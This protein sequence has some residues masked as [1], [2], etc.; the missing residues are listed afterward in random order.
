[1]SRLVCFFSVGTD[2]K[3]LV[4]EWNGRSHPSRYMIEAALQL[5]IVAR[6]DDAI[7][8]S[9][10]LTEKTS[11]L[12]GVMKAELAGQNDDWKPINVHSTG[13][14]A[15][16]RV[17]DTM[18]TTV[19]DGDRVFIEPTNGPRPFQM[20]LIS[21]ALYL[22]ALRG[23]VR[24]ERLVYG[25][26]PSGTIHDITFVLELFDWTR[27]AHAFAG[28]LNSRPLLERLRNPELDELEVPL[29][30]GLTP[31]LFTKL[32]SFRLPGGEGLAQREALGLV[33]RRLRRLKVLVDRT[34]EGTLDLSWLDAELAFI[35]ELANAGR[36]SDATR[37][38][39]EWCVNVVL[40]AMGNTREW[41]STKHRKPAEQWLLF[42]HSHSPGQAPIPEHF[43]KFARLYQRL[44]RLR[45]T[46]SHSGY[47]QDAMALPQLAEAREH[48]RNARV[49]WDANRTCIITTQ[50]ARPT[51]KKRNA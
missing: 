51:R 22:R 12:N 50:L 17:I 42:G 13:P 43:D 39:R 1:M 26:S 7:V 33:D 18:L 49:W 9:P 23:E 36:L 10:I 8:F 34:K 19:Q 5:G 3:S 16:E 11:H 35:E 24:V 2:P 40:L 44:R 38:L 14:K 15:V 28:A 48:V 41:S 32:R 29:A 21:G 45:N 6:N 25:E 20:A 27:A 37:V 47:N 46:L 4:Y 31:H 30:G